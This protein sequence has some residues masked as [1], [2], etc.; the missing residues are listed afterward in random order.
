MLKRILRFFTEN[1]ALK[2]AAVAL[3]ILLWLAVRAD[4]PKQA[5]FTNIPV[6]VDLRDPDWRLDGDPIPSSVTV[7]VVGSTPELMELTSDPPRIVYPVERVNDSTET[8]V[9][10]PQWVQLPASVRETRVVAI[11][12]DTIR[13]R[14]ERLASRM[15]PV[16][17]RTRGDLPNGLALALPIQTNP[18]LVRVHGPAQALES[19]DSVPLMPVEL[20]GLRSTTNVPAPV[21]TAAI[22]ATFR[23][24]P[25]T[26][27]VVLRVMPVI[28]Q[29]IPDS[30]RE[31]RGAPF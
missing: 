7:V 20:S 17:V 2:L 4:V 19:L 12:P 26:V 14:Y 8:Q 31:R 13:L 16:R 21:D 11:R 10:P 22:G 24:E 28:T 1:W 5:R 18:A 3:A 15:L 29:P 30:A 9:L 25:R 23:F 6:E 27:N